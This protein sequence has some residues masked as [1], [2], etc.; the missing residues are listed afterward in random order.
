MKLIIGVLIA[1]AY[2]VLSGLA[3]RASQG[4]WAQGQSDLGFWW[5]VIGTLLGIAGTGA[6]IGTWKHTRTAQD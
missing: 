6:L 4:G 1:A 2:A 3:F 5:A